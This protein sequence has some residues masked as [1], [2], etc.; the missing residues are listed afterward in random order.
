MLCHINY[1][2]TH[3]SCKWHDTTRHQKTQKTWTYEKFEK[4]KKEEL[5][6]LELM[7]GEV[8][9]SDARYYTIVAQGLHNESW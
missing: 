4:N 7:T 6:G 8:F 1:D 3:V 9:C 2:T 5:L